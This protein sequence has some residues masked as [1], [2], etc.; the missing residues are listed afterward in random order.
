MRD[1]IIV[2]RQRVFLQKRRR[3][4]YKERGMIKNL[5]HHFLPYEIEIPNLGVEW[6]RSTEYTS[7]KKL[8]VVPSQFVSLSP[9]YVNA[10]IRGVNI[11]RRV[12]GQPI[13]AGVDVSQDRKRAVQHAGRAHRFIAE[14]QGE[15]KS[16]K[17][18]RETNDKPSKG[19]EAYVG[20][21]AFGVVSMIKRYCHIFPSRQHIEVSNKKATDIAGDFNEDTLKAQFYDTEG[22]PC[23]YHDIK[24][25]PMSKAEKYVSTSQQPPISNVNTKPIY[26]SITNINLLW[27]LI[28]RQA[29][30]R[31]RCCPKM[32]NEFKQ[33]VHKWRCHTSPII[34]SLIGSLNMAHYNWTN[35]ISKFN[36]G[37][38]KLYEKGKEAVENYKINQTFEVM[39]KNYEIGYAKE[40]KGS[41]KP[42]FLCC[43][44]ESLR[45]L[46]GPYNWVL[47]DL[48]K[49]VFNEYDTNLSVVYGMNSGEVQDRI[50]KKI[51]E[52]KGCV[53][54]LCFDGSAHDSNQHLPILEM[55]DKVVM[56]DWVRKFMCFMDLPP[57]F[58]HQILDNL[59]RREAPIKAYYPYT[60]SLMFRGK[61]TGTTFTGHP[62]RTTF[63]NSL[64][65]ALYVKFA[66]RTIPKNLWRVFI[67]GDDIL[68]A[69]NK[70]HAS[71]VR[72]LMEKVYL[73]KDI[74]DQ[75]EGKQAHGLGQVLKHAEELSSTYFSFLSKD[76]YYKD[77]QV[78][79]SRKINRVVFSRGSYKLR[80]KFTKSNHRS[81]VTHS[82]KEY[83]KAPVI[84]NYLTWRIKKGYTG[85]LKPEEFE[86]K[87]RLYKNNHIP[88]N[89]EPVFLDYH[90][91]RMILAQQFE[92]GL[93]AEPIHDMEFVSM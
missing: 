79:L 88:S 14:K 15:L 37:K 40:V 81:N 39:Q 52:I 53:E 58:N 84:K 85:D 38:R 59:Y 4:N 57:Q 33:F 74:Y 82:I 45:A 87:W 46:L 90:G 83:G 64:R 48:L 68:V 22:N 19:L 16:R 20:G 30:S 6:K 9:S 51:K 41:V 76:G 54:F 29:G 61:I 70:E 91:P 67:S 12:R 60:R 65:V 75:S 78:F 11:Q 43:P 47:T 5:I 49:L 62:T 93:S 63:G 69:V 34:T 50:E 36:P 32:L 77:G 35:Y 18:K 28:N 86:A 42:R 21:S 80:P 17:G 89:A 2:D 66:L 55:V 1:V 92:H 7:F 26:A 73:D 44:H 56:D 25:L 10:L 24:D 23:H 72:R 13:L 31:M 3:F 71:L 8:D 27:A